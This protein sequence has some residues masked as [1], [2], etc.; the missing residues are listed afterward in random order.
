M[1]IFMNPASDIDSAPQSAAGLSVLTEDGRTMAQ[2][3][4]ETE[5]AAL[6][7]LQ[8]G[9]S[10]APDRAGTWNALN[11]LAIDASQAYTT[12]TVEVTDAGAAAMDRDASYEEWALALLQYDFAF[13]DPW[14]STS[15]GSYIIHTFGATKDEYSAESGSAGED[16]RR[17]Q[18]A[19]IGR[20]TARKR[21]AARLWQRPAPVQIKRRSPDPYVQLRARLRLERLMQRLSLERMRFE[22]ER[23]EHAAI[24]RHD[25]EEMHRTGQPLRSEEEPLPRIHAI[26]PGLLPDLPGADL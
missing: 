8:A 26:P 10:H 18:K 23:L 4:A 25:V 17:P 11:A 5:R 9:I 2:I 24:Y 19:S 6:E 13:T 3:L 21:T 1:R 14:S 12:I 22:T 7:T 15:S 20:A 16:A